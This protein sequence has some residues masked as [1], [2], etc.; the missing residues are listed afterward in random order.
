MR[1]RPILPQLTESPPGAGEG[2]PPAP[3]GFPFLLRPRPTSPGL[4]L[5]FSWSAGKPLTSGRQAVGGAKM[6]EER[7]LTVSEEVV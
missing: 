1:Q 6:A 4:Q 7:V 2:K 3:L 5:P